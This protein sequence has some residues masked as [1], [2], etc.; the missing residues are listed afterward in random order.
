MSTLNIHSLD[1][2]NLNLFHPPLFALIGL[3]IRIGLFLA[4]YIK[5]NLKSTDI[6]PNL[7]LTFDAINNIQSTT[8]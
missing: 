1:E 5:I 7:D 3:F 2:I 4:S 6:E 8:N